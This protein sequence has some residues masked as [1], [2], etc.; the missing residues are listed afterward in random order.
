MKSKVT[1]Q[2]F[3]SILFI[4]ATVL[5][6][7][8]L[9]C[10]FLLYS[11]RANVL[12]I[13]GDMASYMRQSVD[14]RLDEIQKNTI[15]LE[16]HSVNLKL[17]KMRHMPFK[18]T[19][20]VYQFCDFMYNFRNSNTLVR[21]L[22]IYYPNMDAVAG[23]TGLYS[24]G[25]YFRLLAQDIQQGDSQWNPAQGLPEDS[26]FLNTQEDGTDHLLFVRRMRYEGEIVGVIVVEIDLDE[27]LRTTDTIDGAAQVSLFGLIVTGRLLLS[28]DSLNAPEAR[29]IDGI[30]LTGQEDVVSAG[31]I[32]AYV[33][34]SFFPGLRYL[35]GYAQDRLFAPLY[36]AG[37]ICGLGIFLCVAA[38]VLLSLR[39][40]RRN[41]RPLED[42]LEKFPAQ[43]EGEPD[44]YRYI[45]GKIDQLL[46]DKF[47]SEEKLQERQTMIGSLFL[48]TVLQGDLADEYAVFNAARQYEVEFE[49][50]VFQLMVVQTS[51]AADEADADALLRR[52]ADLN[53]DVLATRKEGRVV[54]LLNPEVP[55]S[56]RT[57]NQLAKQML[58]T[59]GQSAACGFG[60]GYDTLDDIHTSY[61]E[62][63][64]ALPPVPA[65]GGNAFGFY[66]RT[67]RKEASRQQGLAAMEA[68]ARQLHAGRYGKAAE[69]LPPLLAEYIGPDVRPV[70]AR[71]RMTALQN[72]LLDELERQRMAGLRVP[73]DLPRRLSAAA[74]TEELGGA[75]R[76][77][78]ALLAKPDA[79][80][81]TAEGSVPE[82]AKAIVR[83]NLT[84]PMLGLYMISEKLGVSNSYLSSSF[85]TTFGIGLVQYINSL[86]IDRAKELILTTDASIKE[87]A[88]QVG[89]TSDVSFIRVFKK[90]E[91]KTPTALRKAAGK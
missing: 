5:L 25:A 60:A 31:G 14:S 19:P 85:K 54:T 72:T 87:I 3:G 17:R 13:S 44:E 23:T 22:Y 6:V 71:R 61:T 76:N 64:Q 21:N 39:V 24:T 84:D 55:F 91:E 30:P 4:V 66:S 40:S 8:L 58:S 88:R 16:Q 33:E 86:R 62:A 53:L 51:G 59:L 10:F 9:L 77:A 35:A 80:A 12:Q 2:W 68:F 56:E 28:G 26:Q 83:Q 90:Y 42:I 81:E 11:L 89:F 74:D 45:S 36:T 34:D 75:A 43:G 32:T 41:A 63:L 52:C 38:A 27:L 20:E 47:D 57:A 67:A 48:N 79:G 18:I 15:Q 1:R 7:A 65:G 82:R 46:Q 73:P 37:V 50:P 29:A 69:A 49:N 70:D 78:L